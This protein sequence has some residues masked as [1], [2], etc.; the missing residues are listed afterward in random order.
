M[1]KDVRFPSLKIRVL[2]CLFVLCFG[3]LHVWEH[4]GGEYHLEDSILTAPNDVSFS[5][6]KPL[7]VS[8]HLISLRHSASSM[9]YESSTLLCASQPPPQ[10]FTLLSDFRV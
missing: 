9:R 4:L 3:R 1:L 6:S 7:K 10:V 8:S 2:H 5:H